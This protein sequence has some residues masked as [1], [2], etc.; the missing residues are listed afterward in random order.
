[1][2]LHPWVHTWKYPWM[3]LVFRYQSL[4]AGT[5]D[6]RKKSERDQRERCLCTVL[7]LDHEF[8]TTSCLFRCQTLPAPC[9][10]PHCEYKAQGKRPTVLGGECGYLWSWALTMEIKRAKGLRDLNRQIWSKTILWGLAQ[11]FVKIL[12]LPKDLHKLS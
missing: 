4:L 2:H 11:V 5:A 1:M 10:K 6:R 9:T 7:F 12:V 3:F 8:E